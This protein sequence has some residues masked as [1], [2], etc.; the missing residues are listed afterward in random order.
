MKAPIECPL[1]EGTKCSYRQNVEQ[2]EE[3]VGQ[4]AYIVSHDLREPLMGLAGFATLLQKRCGDKLTPE[5]RHFLDQIINGTKRMDAKLNDLL[6]FSR[7]GRTK[8][9]GSF[10][11]GA[12]VEEAKRSLVRRIAETEATIEVKGELPV[13]RGDR[14][15][16]AQVFQNLFSNSLKY[17]RKDVLP[18]VTVEAQ[19]HEDGLWK[20]A[21]R[22]NGIGFDM[23]HQDRVFGVFQ[24]LYTVEEYPGT[25]IGLA[26]ARKIVERHGGRI[27][28]WSEPNAGAIF[29]F[30]LPPAQ[31]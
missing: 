24:R 5:C 3:D 20:V 1:P 9:T 11:L 16:V 13:V 18:Q 14:S 27:W 8:P 2:L 23:R 28:T 25:G 12:A 17:R 21:V 7:A 10:P 30:T 6:A 22:D 19:V 4:F 26:I 15:M 29:Y 31:P